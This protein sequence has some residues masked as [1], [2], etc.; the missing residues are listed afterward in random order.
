ME[1]KTFG[2]EQTIT[3]M[4]G[5]LIYKYKFTDDA[6][7]KKMSSLFPTKDSSHERSWFTQEQIQTACDM[8]DASITLT[9]VKTASALPLEKLS[10]LPKSQSKIQVF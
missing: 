4:Y 2:V 7:T 10:Y 1:T 9:L 6:I 5:K 8:S 3:A